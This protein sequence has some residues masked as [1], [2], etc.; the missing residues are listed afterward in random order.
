MAF[1][2]SPTKLSLFRQCR[3]R[4]RF[5]YV[6]RLGPT[7]KRPRPHLVMGAH[8]HEALRLLYARVRPER[9]SA[10]VAER[11]LRRSW[12]RG[13]VGFASVEEERSFGQRAVAM[14]RRF[15]ALTDLRVDPLATEQM[16]EAALEPDLVLVGRVD[17]VNAEADDAARVV[18]YKTGR[19]RGADE[20]RSTQEWQAAIY[21]HLV[22]SVLGRRVTRVE[23]F[24]LT[25]GVKETIRADAAS[26]EATLEAVRAQ[27]REIGRERDFPP[28]PGPLCAY[29][30]YLRICDAGR[31]AVAR[32]AAAGLSGRPADPSPRGSRRRDEGAGS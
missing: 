6:D 22:E 31:D 9:R 5:E 4:Y 14:I 2:A 18:D 8:V 27:V 30:D 25:D 17:R 29:C 15:C 28:S 19:R 26:R 7:F 32:R 3:R 13:R 12:R 1:R 21:A 16:H 24:Y 23:M 20:D 11:I 10:E